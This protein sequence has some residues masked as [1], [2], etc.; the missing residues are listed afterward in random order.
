MLYLPSIEK[1]CLIF[2]LKGG[3][4]INEKKSEGMLGCYLPVIL[5][6]YI[7]G[8]VMWSFKTKISLQRSDS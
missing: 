7:P 3:A 4:M 2:N 8:H 6:K 1:M 5:N